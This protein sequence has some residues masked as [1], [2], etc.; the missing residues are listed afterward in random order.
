MKPWMG[1]YHIELILD[2][3]KSR[4]ICQV[5]EWGSGGSTIALT[6]AVNSVNGRLVSVEH[7]REWY[8]KT[9]VGLLG[10]EIDTTCTS[11]YLIEDS[12]HYVSTPLLHKGFYDV[13]VIDGWFGR[14]IACLEA[15]APYVTPG[16]VVFVHDSQN[17]RY[18]CTISDLYDTVISS[19]PDDTFE[20]KKTE[21]WCGTPKRTRVPTP[22]L[23]WINDES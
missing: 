3:V 5:L 7:S 13:V 20:N 21:L 14:R 22:D 10:S 11:L 23:D 6:E 15:V 2:A 4:Q 1:S 9:K 16:G 8:E 12:E 18:D 19:H 17:P